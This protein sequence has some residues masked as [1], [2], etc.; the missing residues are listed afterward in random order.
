LTPKNLIRSFRR[1]E[2][3]LIGYFAYVAVLPPFFPDRPHAHFQPALI[4]AAIFALQFALAWAERKEFGAA[5]A[6]IRDWMPIVLTLIA[7]QEM[8]IFLPRRFDHH[9]ESEWIR[10][11][12]RLLDGWHLRAL[13]E[14]F[15]PLIPFYLELCYLVVYGLAAYCVGLLYATGNRRSIDVFLTFYLA[16]T[17][18]AYALFPFFPSQPPRLLYPAAV[19]PTVTTWARS[20]NLWVLKKGTIHVGVFPSAHVSSA[21]AAAWGAFFVLPRKR[22]AWALLIYACSVSLATIYGRYHYT[23]DVMA[24]IGISVL[25]GTICWW[26]G[27]RGTRPT[28]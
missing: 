5:V 13:L 21:F 17:L 22:I 28:P 26:W 14:S 8:E 18:G 15:G 11:D 6:N 2:W 20:V 27:S 24:G 10:Q 23:A 16:G 25:A 12:V 3:I 9:L 1:S 7:F 19:M 4:A